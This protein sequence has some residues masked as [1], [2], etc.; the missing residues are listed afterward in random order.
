MGFFDQLGMVN[1]GNRRA[2]FATRA[3]RLGLDGGFAV[4]ESRYRGCPLRVVEVWQQPYIPE[5]VGPDVAA[6]LDEPAQQRG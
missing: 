6:I 5:D 1:N 3:T 4:E 2:R